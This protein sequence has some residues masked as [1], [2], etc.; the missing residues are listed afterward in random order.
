MA[1]ARHVHI[2]DDV[3]E[4]ASQGGSSGPVMLVAL[5][6]FLDAGSAGRLASLSEAASSTWAASAH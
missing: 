4:L 1:E 2:V 5:D 3:P 6:G